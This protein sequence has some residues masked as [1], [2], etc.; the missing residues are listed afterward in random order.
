MFSKIAKKRISEKYSIR[1]SQDLNKNFPFPFNYDHKNL[2]N[3]FFKYKYAFFVEFG[4][5]IR[6][7]MSNK[8]TC[9]DT[10]IDAKTIAVF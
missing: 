2:N 1:D 8:N 5:K 4:K 9:T 3:Q 7:E 6:N 10:G